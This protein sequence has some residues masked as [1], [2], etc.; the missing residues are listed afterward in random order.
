MALKINDLAQGPVVDMTAGR[1]GK[2]QL[3]PSPPRSL[4]GFLPGDPLVTRSLL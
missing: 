4:G 1:V 3:S 2:E